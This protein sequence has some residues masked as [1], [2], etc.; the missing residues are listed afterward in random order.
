MAGL[1]LSCGCVPHTCCRTARDSDYCG[2]KQQRLIS[3]AVSTGWAAVFPVSVSILLCDVQIGKQ[4]VQCTYILL[5]IKSSVSES[6]TLDCEH[7]I[8]RVCRVHI[9]DDTS[10]STCLGS[11][12]RYESSKCGH[13][14]TSINIEC[15]EQ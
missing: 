12:C 5:M 10:L 8:P 15:V 13:N 4:P 9:R 7:H 3:E 2:W 14:P 1:S 11:K 6:C